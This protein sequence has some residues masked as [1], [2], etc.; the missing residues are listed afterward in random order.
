MSNIGARD[1]MLEIAKGTV[2][3]TSHVNK[4]GKAIDVDLAT[5]TDV[6]DGADGVTSTDIWVPPTVARTHDIAST[7]AN[8]D[9][10][11]VGTGARTINI[12][13]LDSNWILQSEDI[14]LNGTSNVATA[15]TYHRIFRMKVLTVGSGGV[16]AGIITA[17]AQTDATVTAAIQAGNNQTLM[18]IYT[19]PADKKA[20]VTNMYASFSASTPATVTGSVKLLMKQDASQSNSPF[21]V[22]HIFG[23]SGGRHVQHLY[24]PYYVATEKTDI[25]VHMDDAS[26]L[27]NKL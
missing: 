4:F 2:H 1:P 16:N 25:K 17:T 8:D 10:D 5:P 27:N 7:D 9:G 6:W 3:G 11:P 15:N 22:K 12:Q 20:Y 13:G 26:S 21:N 23:I 19:V 18:A 14:T 24:L